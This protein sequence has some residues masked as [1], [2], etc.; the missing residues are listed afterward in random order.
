MFAGEMSC[1]PVNFCLD[2][3]GSSIYSVYYVKY[4]IV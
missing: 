4:H 2:P 1:T 3:P